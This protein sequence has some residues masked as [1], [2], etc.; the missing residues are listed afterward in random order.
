MVTCTHLAYLIK[1][2]CM[3]ILLSQD[4]RNESVFPG[5]S[6]SFGTEDKAL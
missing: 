3:L 1:G 2:M 4:N 6:P 5:Y